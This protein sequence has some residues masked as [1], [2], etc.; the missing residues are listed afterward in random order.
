MPARSI[1]I[2]F[3]L[4]LALLLV[5]GSLQ[6]QTA[7]PAA[8]TP[9][10]PPSPVSGIRN[11]ISAGDLLSAESVLEVHREKNGEDGAWLQGLAWLA[12]GALLLNDMEKAERYARQTR[13][14]CAKRFA[15]GHTLEKNH[16]LEIALGAAIET[17]AQRLERTKG[18]TAA[19]SMLRN[20]LKRYNGPTAFLS[21][22]HKRLNMLVL[23]GGAAPAWV[24]ED[25]VGEPPPTLASL[26]GKPVVLFLWA[27]GCG[28][29]KAQSASLARSLDRYR[30]T[31]LRCVAITRYYDDPPL[32]AREKARVD[33]VWTA[34]YSGVGA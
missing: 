28:D 3:V 14:A 10:P 23:E 19:A 15:N 11:K 2:R 27:E 5:T 33:S 34:V 31:D 30:G 7:P 17:D 9:A 20:E 18:K 1:L 24:T 13:D 21:R 22:L 8:T 26:K 4:P 25:F 29:C 32:Q 12:R 6:A 16:D